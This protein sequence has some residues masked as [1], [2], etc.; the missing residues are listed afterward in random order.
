MTVTGDASQQAQGM[1]SKFDI[2]TKNGKKLDS[3]TSR[4]PWAKKIFKLFIKLMFNNYSKGPVVF[5]A[6]DRPSSC[7]RHALI[8][9]CAAVPELRIPA[10]A[11]GHEVHAGDRVA[12]RRTRRGSRR[13]TPFP[14][15]RHSRTA[16]PCTCPVANRCWTGWRT[17]SSRCS[18]SRC[19]GTAAKPPASPRS[20]TPATTVWRTT[21]SPSLTCPLCTGTRSPAR[22]APLDV[23]ICGRAACRDAG[24][25]F[26]TALRQAVRMGGSESECGVW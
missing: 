24:Q 3:M 14:A 7:R 19:C 21:T 15:P 25:S 5:L 26:R 6:T 23:G 18:T 20:S 22:V 10:G 13:T 11:G 2:S 1:P 16:V 9:A 12:P 4:W 8:G 17:R